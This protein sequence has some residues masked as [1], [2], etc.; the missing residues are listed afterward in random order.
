LGQDLLENTTYSINFGDGIVDLHESNP[1][2]SNRFV[3]STGDFLDSLVVTG[4]IK[5]A[6]DLQP[7]EDV[8]VMLYRQLED[9]IPA[10]ERPTYFAKTD[11]SGAFRIENIRTDTYQL[12]ALVDKN[13]NYLFDLPNEGIAFPDNVVR[14]VPNDS[15]RYALSLFEEDVVKQ[16]VKGL[17]SSEYGQLRVVF[18]RPT[19]GVTLRPLNR[20]FKTSWFLPEVVPTRDTVYYWLTGTEGID[21]LEIE[22]S[23]SS[24]IWDTIKVGLPER[25][26]NDS[27][28]RRSRK[29]KFR[30]TVG[31]NA[32]EGSAYDYYQPFRMT[33]NH[34]HQAYQLERIRMIEGTDTFQLKA[35]DFEVDL[36]S[37]TLKRTLKPGLDYELFIP[38]KTFQDIFGLA[39]DTVERKFRTKTPEDYGRLDLNVQV[40]SQGHPY[41]V[42]FM[43]P[44]FKEL[45]RD[46]IQDSQTI[47]YQFLRPGKYKIKLLYDR[48]GNGR[49]DTGK[50]GTK[51]Q[52]EKVLFYSGEI[53]IRANW[54]LELDWV[55][56]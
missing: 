39:N 3:F 13:S 17:S 10:K 16:F 45:R 29:K 19:A 35:S 44:Q 51:R 30:L 54:D 4:S 28:K 26:T 46:T 37:F 48:N 14:P 21:S 20:S 24:S 55:V 23:D 9:S 22:V 11:A 43:D 18:N 7:V 1:L 47:I 52:P 50:Y 34:P 2:D 38:P 5:N 31:M 27:R 42:Q 56:D 15:V 41:I 40:S 12:F 8:L 32:R 49:W 33:L 53:E 6:F 25:P 36:R